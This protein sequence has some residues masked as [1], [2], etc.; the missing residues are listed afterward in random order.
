MSLYDKSTAKYLVDPLSNVQNKKIKPQITESMRN[1][2]INFSRNHLRNCFLFTYVQIVDY[3]LCQ[4]SQYTQAAP[5][6]YISKLH[7]LLYT[8]VLH[9]AT[10]MSLLHSSTCCA[11]HTEITNRNN[12]IY[13]AHSVHLRNVNNPFNTKNWALV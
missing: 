4:L 8:S 12:L 5:K 9:G 11:K 10:N 13:I 1:C 7:I 3:I 2:D 6:Q